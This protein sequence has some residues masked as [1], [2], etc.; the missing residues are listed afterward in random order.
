MIVVVVVVTGVGGCVEVG[1]RVV[2]ACVVGVG[3][4]VVG[5]SVVG[6][7][8]VG[9]NVVGACVVG[10]TVVGAC[11]V[12]GIVVVLTMANMKSQARS[13]PPADSQLPP[14]AP[15]GQ[16]PAGTHKFAFDL[17]PNGL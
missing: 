11:V 7:C 17:A 12:G 16:A 1:G 9:G 3:A 10:D 13:Q 4:C 2:G 15:P 6:T 14:K 5:G 8:V